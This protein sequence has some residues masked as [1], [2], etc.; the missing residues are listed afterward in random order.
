MPWRDPPVKEGGEE[1]PQEHLVLH[2][3]TEVAVHQ[4][5]AS[6]VDPGACS[7]QTEDSEAQGMASPGC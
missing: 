7:R 6:D 4:L 5:A 1:P 2:P 3:C